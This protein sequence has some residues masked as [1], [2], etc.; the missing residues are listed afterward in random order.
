MFERKTSGE[1]N[2]KRVI[3]MDINHLEQKIKTKTCTFLDKEF[4]SNI[5]TA[6]EKNDINHVVIIYNYN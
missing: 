3:Q 2:S 5:M 4:V 6:E 1:A